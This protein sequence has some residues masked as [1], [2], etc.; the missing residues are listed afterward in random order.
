MSGRKMMGDNIFYVQVGRG[1]FCNHKQG[2]KSDQMSVG[3]DA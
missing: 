3:H 1:Y 2:E